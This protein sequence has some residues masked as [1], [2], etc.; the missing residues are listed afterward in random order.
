[1]QIHTGRYH[2]DAIPNKRPIL[3]TLKLPVVVDKR[4]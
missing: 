4:L 2:A 3:A 1:V